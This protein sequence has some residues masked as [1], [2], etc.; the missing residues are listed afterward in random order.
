MGLR[1]GAKVRT[2][3]AVTI[4][5]SL[6]LAGCPAHAWG[7]TGTQEL[8]IQQAVDWALKSDPNIR[9]NDLTVRELEILRDKAAEAVEYIPMGGMVPEATHAVVSQYQQVEINLQAARQLQQSQKDLTA[10]NVIAA[11]ISAIKNKND[12]ELA[13]LTLNKL[14]KQVAINKVSRDLGMV[15][16][17]E[18]EILEN[19]FSQLEA[20]VKAAE[21]AYLSS[22]LSLNEIM[23]QSKDSRFQLVSRPQL[24]GVDKDPLETELSRATNDSVLV[25]RAQKELEIEEFNQNLI[26]MDGGSVKSSERRSI[27]LNRARANLDKAKQDARTSVEGLYY[28]IDAVEKQI[29]VAELAYAQAEKALNDAEVRYREL[30]L[31][32]ALCRARRI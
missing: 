8:N 26:L 2:Y 12:L 4:T 25:L 19:S 5:V 32:S 14:K 24:N 15:S 18:W 21:A 29:K 13:T 7:T 23:G 11:Y 9:I 27:D 30:Y 31:W 16:S 22:I 1:I 10:K 17:Y 6:L 3:L 28:G 20:G